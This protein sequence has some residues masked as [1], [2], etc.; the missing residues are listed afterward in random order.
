MSATLRKIA[1][2]HRRRYAELEKTVTAKQKLLDRERAYFRD[3]GIP[4]MWEEV[5][6]I[7]VIN[8]APT[9]V[10]GLIVTFED[11]VC[12]TDEDYREQTGI[13]L[14]H[15]NSTND[16]YV[17]NEGSDEHPKIK[18]FQAKHNGRFR[19]VLVD[20]KDAKKK[21]V[22][23]FICYLAQRITPHML[24]EMDIDLS[25]PT[26]NKKASRRFLQVATNE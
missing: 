23:S 7:K 21:F 4:E 2:Y 5:K 6:H 14:Y 12:Q 8:P 16:W 9:Q 25:T 3:S 10:S 15:G 26:E 18:Y 13:S 11:L 17:H 1:D 24:L 22:D 20:N 19:G